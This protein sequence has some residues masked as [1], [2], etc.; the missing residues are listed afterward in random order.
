MSLTQAAAPRAADSFVQFAPR[1]LA[2]LTAAGLYQHAV[3]RGEG[4]I[5]ADGPLVVK[6]GVHT[7]RSASDKFIV[8]NPESEAAIWWDA[9]QEMSAEQFEQLRVDMLAH[10]ETLALFSQDLRGGG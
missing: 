5:A 1:E 2:N 4:D 10:A 6:T 7:G 9:N 8:R 3:A